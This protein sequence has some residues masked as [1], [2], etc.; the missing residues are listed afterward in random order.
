M[1]VFVRTGR[2]RIA[3]NGRGFSE[4]RYNWRIQYVLPFYIT[5]AEIILI[6]TKDTQRV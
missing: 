1:E 3:A 2:L 6:S 4:W 5:C